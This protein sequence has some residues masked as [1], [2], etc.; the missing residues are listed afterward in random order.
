[1]Q[2]DQELKAGRKSLRTVPGGLLLGPTGARLWADYVEARPGFAGR[3]DFIHKVNIPLLFTVTA[4]GREWLLDTAESEWMPS[5]LHL[6]CTNDYF[7]F[8]ESKFISWD[9]C[10]VS[11]QTWTNPGKGSLCSSW[12]WIRP[13]NFPVPTGCAAASMFLTT[14]ST[15]MRLCSRVSQ[16][17]FTRKAGRL[18]RGIASRS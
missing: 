11:C 17:C 7:T 1:M 8:S 12:R 3:F 18:P 14:A 9:D 5:Q 4:N 6:A 10:A 2:L 16:H 15:W 13:S